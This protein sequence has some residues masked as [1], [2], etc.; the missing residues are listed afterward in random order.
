[1]K[2]ERFYFWRMI[3]IMK[4]SL[5]E[6][7]PLADTLQLTPLQDSVGFHYEGEN[8]GSMMVVAYNGFTEKELNAFKHADITFKLA[9]LKDIPFLITQFKGLPPMDGPILFDR[10]V[11]SKELLKAVEDDENAGF[12]FHFIAVDT[13]NNKHIVVDQRLISFSNIFSKRLLEAAVA[14]EEKQIPKEAQVQAAIATQMQY[15]TKQLSSFA[16][17][18]FKFIR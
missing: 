2:Q 6:K 15:T 10:D 4:I 7:F 9:V 14:L 1:M 5:G 3:A 16:K 11:H 17:Y 18:T 13:K 12:S 8:G